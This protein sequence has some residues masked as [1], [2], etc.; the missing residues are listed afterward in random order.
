MT[1]YINRIGTAKPDHEI[2]G[3]FITWAERQLT[4]PRDIVL[5]RRMAARSGINKR[6]SVLP[7]APG[8]G[9]PIDTG[10]FYCGSACKKDPLSGVIGVQKG[11]LIS[12][13]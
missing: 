4:E 1:V 8:G 5:L 12:M 9:S 7:V 11:P 10:G 3:A 6:W 13:V 2:S